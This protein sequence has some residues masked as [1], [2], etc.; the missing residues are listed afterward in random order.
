MVQ[1]SLGE[2]TI[3]ISYLPDGPNGDCFKDNFRVSF[4]FDKRYIQANTARLN[5]CSEV[6]RTFGYNMVIELEI[7]S[8]NGSAMICTVTITRWCTDKGDSPKD[9]QDRVRKKNEAEWK[10][11][12][13]QSVLQDESEAEWKS[14]DDQ[15]VLQ[16]VSQ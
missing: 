11:L 9:F 5:N 3:T 10:S 7:S 6:I 13:D 8:K 1:E 15:S 16:W 12:D 2:F 4:R 14:L